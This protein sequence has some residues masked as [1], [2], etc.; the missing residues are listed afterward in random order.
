MTLDIKFFKE[1]LEKEKTLLEKELST[2]AHEKNSVGGWEAV[3]TTLADEST[4]AD[5]NEVADKIEEFGT[6]Q[7]ITE[8][9]KEEYRDVNDALTKINDKTFGACSVCGECIEEDRMKA[10]TSAPTCKAHMNG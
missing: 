2:V 4:D 1:K 7:A 9:L 5:P 6:N 3:G 8:R 10:N